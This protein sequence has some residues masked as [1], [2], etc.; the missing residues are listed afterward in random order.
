MRPLTRE[1]VEK[2]EGDFATATR[3]R[4]A[5]KA[6]NYDAACFHAQQCAE[7][8]LK[9]RRQ[10]AALSFG[11]THNLTALLDLL[12]PIEPSW[13]TL[14]PHLRALTVFAVEVRYSGE[15]ADKTEAREAVARCREV[16][17]RVRVSL[18]LEHEGQK[19]PSH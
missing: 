3:E 19:D 5:R 12:A 1:W 7:K 4:R 14:R 17:H 8:Y 6:P 18:G 9:A 15:S 10:E 2:A 16:R 11:K 13:E